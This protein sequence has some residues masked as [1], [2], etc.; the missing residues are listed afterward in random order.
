MRAVYIK[1]IVY[2]IST[3]IDTKL[4]DQY[5]FPLRSHFSVFIF[6]QLTNLI[7]R[8]I[9]DEKIIDLE[10]LDVKR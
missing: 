9:T 5:F 3:A 7:Y 1:S 2:G 10:H 4:S 8:I 6:P